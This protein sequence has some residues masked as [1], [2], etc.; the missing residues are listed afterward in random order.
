MRLIF[1]VTRLYCGVTSCFC[2]GA[3][4]TGVWVHC[5]TCPGRARNQAGESYA[6]LDISDRPQTQPPPVANTGAYEETP[7]SASTDQSPA[8]DLGHGRRH[9]PGIVRLCSLSPRT[10]HSHL[11]RDSDVTL[12]TFLWLVCWLCCACFVLQ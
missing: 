11:T 8:Q 9:C 4:A 2:Q 3:G 12:P 7:F 10:G 1:F 5:V 6:T